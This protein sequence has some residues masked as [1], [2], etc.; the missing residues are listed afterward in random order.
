MRAASRRPCEYQSEESAPPCGEMFWPQTK[1]QKVC[2]THVLAR[3]RQVEAVRNKIAS[4]KRSRLRR[5]AK[6]RLR[7]SAVEVVIAGAQSERKG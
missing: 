5:E 4:E 3:K 6:G 7:S 1:K 2:G